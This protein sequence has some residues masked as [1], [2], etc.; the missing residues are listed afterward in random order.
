[1]LYKAPGRWCAL[2]NAG[3]RVTREILD[4][5][6]RT[7]KSV[8]FGGPLPIQKKQFRC[9]CSHQHG[10][11]V[12]QKHGQLAC[13]HD[14]VGPDQCSGDQRPYA[15]DI[16][17]ASEE[18]TEPGRGAQSPERSSRLGPPPYY[19]TGRYSVPGLTASYAAWSRYEHE[20]PDSGWF[21]ESRHRRCAKYEIKVSQ[22]LG[23][24]Y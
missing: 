4:S 1:M 18:E 20:P 22:V 14:P 6:F 13:S 23:G 17:G 5:P 8:V 16:P 10:I 21:P 11:A 9:S 12:I 7:S 24:R 2:S 19:P 3:Q 15:P